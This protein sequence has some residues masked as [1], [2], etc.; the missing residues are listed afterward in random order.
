MSGSCWKIGSIGWPG[1]HR[2]DGA[3]A[4]RSIMAWPRHGGTAMA[5]IKE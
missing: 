3:Q 5:R 2:P 1:R 4:R